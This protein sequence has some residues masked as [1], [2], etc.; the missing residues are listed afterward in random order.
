M[1]AATCVRCGA[2]KA[3]HIAYP[4]RPLLCPRTEG[5]TY[6]PASRSAAADRQLGQAFADSYFALTRRNVSAWEWFVLKAS[7]ST[8]T[9]RR[10]WGAV[11]MEEQIRRRNRPT[12]AERAQD[13]AKAP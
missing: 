4:G 10:L 1:T 9:A 8:R 7:G 5:G 6:Q 11:D 3:D 13:A 12:E 2:L